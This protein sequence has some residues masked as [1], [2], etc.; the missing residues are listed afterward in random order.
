MA[1]LRQSHQGFLD[2]VVVVAVIDP[3]S[4]EAVAQYWAKDRLPF[5]GLSDPEGKVLAALGQELKLLKLGR[6]PAQLVV[7]KS[8]IVRF[9]HYGASMSD[10][11]SPDDVLAW[12]DSHLAAKS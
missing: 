3:D 9:A 5:A 2:R 12:V 4:P 6:M 8:G 1:Q 7:D 11:P 10:I